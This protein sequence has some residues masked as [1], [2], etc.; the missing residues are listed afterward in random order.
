MD[1]S[2][3]LVRLQYSCQSRHQVWSAQN[4]T[5]T[6]RSR[7]TRPWLEKNILDS[8]SG[9]QVFTH[10][11]FQKLLMCYTISVVSQIQVRPNNLTAHWSCKSSTLRGRLSFWASR[12]TVGYWIPAKFQVIGLSDAENL[13]VSRRTESTISFCGGSSIPLN[14]SKKSKLTHFHLCEFEAPEHMYC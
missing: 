12:P 10:H 8:L 2:A 7:G 3:F 11:E 4:V 13:N 5:V 14:H 9:I 1:S 6:F